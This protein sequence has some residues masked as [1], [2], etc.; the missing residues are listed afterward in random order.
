[1]PRYQSPLPLTPT[2]EAE[3]EDFLIAANFCRYR[4]LAALLREKYSLEIPLDRLS[5]FGRA[6]KSRR[7]E[8]R[9]ISDRIRAVTAILVNDPDRVEII[10][11]LGAKLIVGLSAYRGIQ[12]PSHT[13]MENIR[14]AL[15]A[16]RPGEAR[17]RAK[18]LARSGEKRSD[19][20]DD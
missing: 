15:T 13:E 10:A 12:G 8:M 3:I 16:E 14:A 9:A 17:R 20:G 2:I 5:K 7:S 6:L 1:M 19:E 18:T 4:E 11:S